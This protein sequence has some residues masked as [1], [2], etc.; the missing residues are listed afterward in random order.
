MDHCNALTT[1]SSV[2]FIWRSHTSHCIA[3]HRIATH[4]I[5][6]HCIATHRIALHCITCHVMSTLNIFSHHSSQN[7]LDALLY[8]QY[9]TLPKSSYPLFDAQFSVLFM[10]HFWKC[11]A[12]TSFPFDNLLS[13]FF[14]FLVN[15]MIDKFIVIYY[16][17]YNLEL[18]LF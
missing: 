15:N 8:V 18:K 14:E 13:F 11:F 10:S 4:R 1:L 12:L 17:S 9:V 5:A 3:L 7:E 6:L 16:I 2:L